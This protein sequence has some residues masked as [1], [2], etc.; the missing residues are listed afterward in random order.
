MTRVYVDKKKKPGRHLGTWTTPSGNVLNVYVW[1]PRNG[2][3]KKGYTE[4]EG[5]CFLQWEQDITVE[6]EWHWHEVIEAEVAGRLRRAM[7]MVGDDKL[8]FGELEK[9][10][11]PA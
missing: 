6:D 3:E 10:E 4:R 8:F 5:Q 11:S 1:M 2:V 9:G 7:E